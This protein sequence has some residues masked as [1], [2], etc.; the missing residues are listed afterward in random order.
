MGSVLLTGG[1]GYIGSHTAKALRSSGREVVVLDSLVTGHREAIQ[2][3]PLVEADIADREIV[4]NTI[5]RYNVKAVIHFAAFLSESESIADP[6]RYYTN[7]FTKTL[8][9]LDTL[10]GESV[11]NFIFSSTAAV[12][13]SPKEIPIQE[14][15]PA[16]PISPYGESKLAVERALPYFERSYGLRFI[17]LRYFNAAGADTDGKLGEDHNPETHLIPNAL[18]ATTGGPELKIYGDDYETKD[19]TC[20]RDYVHVSDLASAHLLAL[21]KLESGNS[22]SVYN[23]GLERA[24]SVF[25]VLKIVENITGNL[26]P[27][28][29][30]SRR[31]GDPAI[32]LASSDRI[33]TELG[34]RPQHEALDTIV[35]SAWSWHRSHPNG[36]ASV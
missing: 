25:N 11:R 27:Y 23:I 4:R 1:A 2:D 5:R 8:E 32:L 19:G 34:W 33:R 24:Y 26:V 18:N 22:S 7:N 36:Y 14:K 17:C 9:L 31:I 30:V 12:Y 13:G 10:I 28:S 16:N 21:E 29:V 20:E 35:E 3:L 6:N 15:C